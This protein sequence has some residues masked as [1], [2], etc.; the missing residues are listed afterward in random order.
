MKGY[1]G[2]SPGLIC[3]PDSEHK[4]QYAENTV[5]EEDKAECCRS[6][7]H[8]CK[9]PLNVFGYYPPVTD[10]GVSEYAEV[11]ALDKPVTNDEEKYCSKKLKIGAKIGIP[12][13]V[14]A[15]V[16]YIKSNIV[17]E[18][19]ESS[20]GDGSAATNTG[21]YSAATNTGYCSAATNTGDRSAASVEGKDSIALAFGVESKAK[22][23]LGC[24]IVLA[25]WGEDDE[26]NR[27]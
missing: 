19:N 5:Y 8:F 14:Q 7:M 18:K 21:Y 12:A 2:F 26:G 25:E 16:E 6:G 1:K 3:E 4:K 27:Q 23:A 22:G 24:Y 9:Y 15:S 10:K 13:L 11:E 20:T 17:E